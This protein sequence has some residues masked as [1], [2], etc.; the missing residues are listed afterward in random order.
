LTKQL[1]STHIPHI[2]VLLLPKDAYKYI[3]FCDL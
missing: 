2:M 1:L 3:Y